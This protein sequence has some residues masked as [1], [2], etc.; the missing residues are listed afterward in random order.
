MTEPK[1]V[2]FVCLGNIC[3]SPIAEAVFLH[4]V[5]QRK[6]EDKWIADSAAT[7]SWHTGSLPDKRALSTLKKHNIP[8]NNTAR[9][10]HRDD[11]I[12]YD[13]IFGMDEH[14]QQDLEEEARRVKNPK[15]KIM[16]LGEMCPEDDV[17]I[18]DPYYDSGSKGFEECYEKCL[19][20]CTAF[21]DKY[22]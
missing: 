21:L 22:S 3:R 8:Y 7:G 10:V 6:L 20:C 12:E 5:K 17:T 4:L 9:Q 15:A 19:K 18:R 1:R 2:L 13:Y 16:L 11:F 14:N